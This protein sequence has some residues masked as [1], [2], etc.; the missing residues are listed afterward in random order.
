M[1]PTVLQYLLKYNQILFEPR[2]AAECAF[3][4]Q[5]HSPTEVILI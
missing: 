2:S 4:P 3:I 5:L 1:T